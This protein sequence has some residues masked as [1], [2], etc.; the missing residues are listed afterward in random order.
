MFEP[1]IVKN[2]KCKD[3]N[4]IV[5]TVIVNTDTKENNKVRFT[6]D[7]ITNIKSKIGNFYFIQFKNNDKEYAIS[8]KVIDDD[9]IIEF[10][11]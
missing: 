2:Y 11:E 1:T 7:E 10:E 8:C 3:G 6:L 4:K 5:E 9:F